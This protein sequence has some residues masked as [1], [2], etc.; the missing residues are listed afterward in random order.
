[1]ENPLHD[2]LLR[3]TSLNQRIALMRAIRDNRQRCRRVDGGPLSGG[4]SRHGDVGRALRG[5]GQALGDLHRPQWR[6]PG[7]RLRP[8][9]AAQ[10]AAMP[11]GPARPGERRTTS[12][13]SSSCAARSAILVFPVA[14]SSLR[15]AIRR[16]G[17]GA[18]R[19]SRRAWRR[20]PNRHIRA[21]GW[22]GSRRSVALA[23][24]AA[25]SAARMSCGTV[26]GAFFAVLSRIGF[27]PCRS[28]PSPSG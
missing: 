28:A 1:M 13:S 19:G 27:A 8:D 15:R 22:A 20:S 12:T 24:G 18:W 23:A 9:G 21:A 5:G 25:S 7:P 3:L 17:R 16:S 2:G 10:P 11:P 4:L 6:H 26:N 14:A